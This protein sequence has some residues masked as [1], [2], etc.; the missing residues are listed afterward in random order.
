MVSGFRRTVIAPESHQCGDGVQS[1]VQIERNR[2][3]LG[4]TQTA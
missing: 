3:Q 2:E 1:G 4:A